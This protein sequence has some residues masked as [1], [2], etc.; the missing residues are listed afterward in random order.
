[1]FVNVVWRLWKGM[2]LTIFTDQ[3]L[4]TDDIVMTSWSW[5]KV[6]MKLGATIQQQDSMLRKTSEQIG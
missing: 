3:H 2:N 1:M 4:N 5:T 6:S